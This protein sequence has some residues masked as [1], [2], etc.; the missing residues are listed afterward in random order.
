[1]NIAIFT[2]ILNP[3]RT[4]FF[5]KMYS[6]TKNNGHY[7]RI[8]AMTG[9]K[10]DRPWKY[11][12]Y[13]REYTRL[14]NSKTIKIRIKNDIYLHFNPGLEK[15]IAEFRP[16]VVVMAGSYLQPT[17]IRLTQL[18]KK[19][20]YMTFFWSES[21][22]KEARGYNSFLLKLRESIRKKL[23][24]K[25][26]GFWYPGEKAKE[27]VDHYKN[28]NAVLIQVPNTV[29]DCFFDVVECDASQKN[30]SPKILFTPARLHPSKGILEFLDIIK[31]IPAS[32]YVWKIAGDG[33]LKD[34]IVAKAKNNNINLELLGNLLPEE[35]KQY[36][37]M[38]DVFLLPSI[39]DANP[40]TC[41]EALWSRLPLFVSEHVGNGSEVV[42]P[43]KNGYIFSYDTPQTATQMLK[44][45][46]N[47]DAQWY[48]EAS[49]VSH[50]IAE[51][52]FRQT[53]IAKK[54][55]DSIVSARKIR[56]K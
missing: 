37:R 46:L 43:G 6:Y 33:E 27:F 17:V 35:V 12:E 11:E 51:D 50:Q 49:E 47:E 20:G 34:E 30:N 7:L 56:S 42:D 38:A 2:N 14:L 28:D 29:D 3:Y 45:M 23:L 1:M 41:V 24:R 21:H 26:D 31:N 18:Q 54:A 10:S 44:E 4:S 36:Y 25:M 19:Y 15:E 32:D 16:D 40:L 48:K 8:Y 9:E 53:L 55:V 39:S 22:F 5:E 13:E 52:C